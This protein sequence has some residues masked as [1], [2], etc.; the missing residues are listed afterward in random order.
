MLG[1]ILDGVAVAAIGLT[2][3]CVA[4]FTARRHG[5]HLRVDG[6]AVAGIL[7]ASMIATF[8]TSGRGSMTHDILL[9]GFAVSA[10][11]DV[12][13]GLI[14]DRVL[15]FAASAIVIASLLQGSLQEAF[16]GAATCCSALAFLWVV[17]RGRGIGLGDV[18]LA[19][20]SGAVLGIG[21][22]MLSL[23]VA[24]VFGACYVVVL[25]IARRLPESRTVAFGPFLALGGAFA[26]VWPTVGP[27]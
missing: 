17:S 18:K 6:V 8:L 1:G 2:L 22:G 19:A 11:S 12:R 25:A 9:A 15:A 27:K 4:S 20:L 24:F 26:M 14:F 21:G 3:S 13:I 5:R 16:G 23:G 10:W 7:L